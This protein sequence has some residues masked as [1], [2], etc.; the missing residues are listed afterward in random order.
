MGQRFARG[1]VTHGLRTIALVFTHRKKQALYV[2]SVCSDF[3]VLY[4]SL[5]AGFS[6][7]DL[8]FLVTKV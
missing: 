2:N 3:I 6:Y 4:W 8:P 7:L 1:V 5:K